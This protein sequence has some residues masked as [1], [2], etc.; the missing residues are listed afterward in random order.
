MDTLGRDIL[1][2]G[3]GSISRGELKKFML[4]YSGNIVKTVFILHLKTKSQ[5]I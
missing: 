2:S 4:K 5:P 1:M 3:N